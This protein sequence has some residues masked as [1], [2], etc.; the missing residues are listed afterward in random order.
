M[1]KN[2]NLSHGE[3]RSSNAHR[4]SANNKKGPGCGQAGGKRILLASANLHLLSA[5]AHR[6]SK[7]GHRVSAINSAEDAPRAWSPSLYDV[8]V[9]S[10]DRTAAILKQICEPAKGADPQ[11][12]LVMLAS[13]P[14]A[15]A[16]DVP[17][18]VVTESEEA[19]I[20]EQLLAIVSGS[21]PSAA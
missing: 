9:F 13:E 8:V 17:D 6:L 5:L 14:V 18:A 15:I 11:L 16:C 12:L 1:P 10:A 19:A 2:S 7:F 21:V 4:S 20:A 3:P